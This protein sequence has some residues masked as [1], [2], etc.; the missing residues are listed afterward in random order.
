M[1]FYCL[2]EE[3]TL[4]FDRM[5]HSKAEKR[6]FVDITNPATSFAPPALS[7]QCL[8]SYAYVLRDWM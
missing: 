4:A 1:L 2:R 5:S 6:S 7:Q 8:K 3:G